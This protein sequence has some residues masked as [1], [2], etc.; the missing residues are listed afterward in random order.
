MQRY[1]D[2]VITGERPF[3]KLPAG[4]RW[5]S[6]LR[7][8]P[9]EPWARRANAIDLAQAGK[10]AE[11]RSQLDEAQHL[12][13]GTLLMASGDAMLR[14]FCGDRRGARTVVQQLKQRLDAHDHGI[15]IA[16][17]HALFG[18]TDSA[19]VWLGRTQWTLNKLTDLRANRW[20][21][22]LRS[23]PRYPL[24]LRTLGL[25]HSNQN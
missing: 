13:P 17:I 12:A 6:F 14:W 18:E 2:Y 3:L 4:Q 9:G 5:S 7:G 15:R 20:L 19:F 1:A 21:D 22:P 16:M 23:D 24:L 11:A 25:R 10:C 8:E